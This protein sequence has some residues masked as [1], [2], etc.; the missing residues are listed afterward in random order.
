MMRRAQAPMAGEK[1]K[2]EPTGSGT[3]GKEGITTK[4]EY[5]RWLVSQE[6]WQTAENIRQQNK[7]GEEIIKERQ[8]RHTTQ[9]LS[10]QQS[11]AVQM[12]KASESLEAHREQNLTLGRAVYEEV[13]GWR[14]GA[15]ATKDE[16]AA[17]GKKVKE[18]IKS[19]NKTAASLAA[20]SETK[21]SKAAITRDDDQKKEKAR[22]D[23]RD[24]MAEQAKKQAEKVRQETGD[25]I[26]DAAKRH[27]YE[28]RLKSANETK[29]DAVKWEK[30]RKEEAEAFSQ[31]Q[32]KRRNKSK[33]ARDAAGKSR[34]ALL[35]TRTEEAIAMREEKK[36][37]AEFHRQRLQEEYQLRAATVKGVI[38]NSY[39][40]P[41]VPAEPTSP[42]GTPLANSFY[43]L[44]NIRPPS[45]QKERPAEA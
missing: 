33:S 7:S 25:A 32:K 34:A 15:K 16:Y 45:P 22:K 38:G 5:N 20:L 17:Y 30:E 31:L 19:E 36:K 18:Q 6:K 23:M 37:L 27:F 39:L 11:A 40:S 8:R 3:P 21:K 29:A 9:G 2:E 44:T 35:T 28:Q 43:S 42:G 26:T 4:A 41:D 12:K 10:R 14:A 13:A 1:S 24:A